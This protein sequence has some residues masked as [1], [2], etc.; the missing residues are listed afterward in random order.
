MNHGRLDT[1]LSRPEDPARTGRDGQEETRAERDEERRRDDEIGLC[2][3]QTH[4]LRDDTVCEEEHE[5]VEK[6]GHLVGL[7]VHKLYLWA[8]GCENHTGAQR[9]K[10]GGRYGNFLGRDIRKHLVYAHIIFSEIYKVVK[11]DTS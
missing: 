7:A 8:V 5:S 3:Y 6:H 2:E 11:R 1:R 9:E 10:K 4:R